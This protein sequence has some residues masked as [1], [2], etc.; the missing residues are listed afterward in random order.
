VEPRSRLV[1]TANRNTSKLI[2]TG[3]APQLGEFFSEITQGAPRKP[4]ASRHFF[5]SFFIKFAGYGRQSF[6]MKPRGLPIR[7]ALDQKGARS[8]SNQAELAVR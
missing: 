7:H 2:Y 5:D 4:G 3:R 8:T 1:A 6:Y